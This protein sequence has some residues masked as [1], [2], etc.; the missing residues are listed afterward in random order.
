MDA[1]TRGYLSAAL[2]TEDPNPGQGE[3]QP[4]FTRLPAD[5][6]AQAEADCKRFQINAESF[7]ADLSS[8]EEERA[9]RDFWYTRNGHGCGFWDGDWP[10]PDATHLTGLAKR[11]GETYLELAP[12]PDDECHCVIIG[13][14]PI[15]APDPEDEEGSEDHAR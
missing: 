9:G 3:Y 8:E 10:E 5:F 4:D 14:C 1:F 13:D 11:L 15:C 2:F 7:L 6:V 12:E